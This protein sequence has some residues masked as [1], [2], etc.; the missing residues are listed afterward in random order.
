MFLKK[1]LIAK[2]FLL[3]LCMLFC[4][5]FV[6]GIDWQEQTDYAKGPLY[7]KNLYLP[8]LIHYNFPSLQAKAGQQ[9]DFNY[10]ISTYFVQDVRYVENNP[11]PKAG[12]RTYDKENIERDYES[13]VGE[14]GVSFNP[15]RELQIGMDMRLI[16]Y[17]G[18]FWDPFVEGFHRVFGF[19][20][21]GREYFLYNQ[22]YIN[23]PNDSG[24]SFFLDE[25]T[26]SFGDIDLWGK[27]TF[28][29]IPR[30]S[31]AVLGAGKIPSGKLNALSGSG[32]P[33]LAFGILSDIRTLWYLTVYAQ[34][35]LV[36]PFNMASYPMFNGLAGAE[37]HPWK[38]FSFN[39]QLNIKT[40]PISGGF[41]NYYFLPQTNLLIGFIV[42]PKARTHHNFK[43]QFY[44]EEDPFTYQGT[45][46]TF[47]LMF[48]HTLNYR[49]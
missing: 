34:A 49:Q 16:A 32:Y 4:V 29:E 27:W 35:G 24:I 41:D 20:N 19:P 15:L 47:N 28:F 18:G 6:F 13:I 3:A 21:G 14:L 36:L 40:S 8:Y 11:L 10:H 2:Q 37:F 25:N 22:L 30:L 12:L 45:D 5:Q 42:Q 17:F 26:L 31:L 23:I 48:S 46:I 9:G 43:W 7:G 44:F 39:L 38:S 33:D 1:C